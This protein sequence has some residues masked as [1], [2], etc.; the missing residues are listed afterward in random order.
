MRQTGC[1][2]WTLQFDATT[3]GRPIKIVSVVDE[4]T[5]ECLGALVDR[6]IT[7]EV[8]I[9]ELDHFTHGGQFPGGRLQNSHLEFLKQTGARCST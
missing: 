1:G 9:D 4:H 8:L 3:G 6:S 5:R 7:A 2:R